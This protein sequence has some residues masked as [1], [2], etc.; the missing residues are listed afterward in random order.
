MG[1]IKWKIKWDKGL[2]DKYQ[3]ENDQK[4]L[5]YTD[6]DKTYVVVDPSASIERKRETLFHELFHAAFDALV[7]GT[8]KPTEEEYVSNGSPLILQAL[9]SKKLRKFLF[10]DA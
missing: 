5:G 7:A 3:I 8:D 6:K 10:P 2:I 4:V 1:P 9:Q